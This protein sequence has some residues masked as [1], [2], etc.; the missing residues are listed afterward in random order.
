M[1]LEYQLSQ[2]KDILQENL[3]LESVNKTVKK[4]LEMFSRLKEENEVQKQVIKDLTLKL[5]GKNK[6]FTLP[7]FISVKQQELERINAKGLKLNEKQLDKVVILSVPK[8]TTFR[9]LKRW[10]QYKRIHFLFKWNFNFF[11]KKL[12]PHTICLDQSNAANWHFQK[13]QQMEEN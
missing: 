13:H 6:K 5:Q 9:T 11:L 7:H 1:K 10:A 3:Q 12:N 4:K 8:L 2:A